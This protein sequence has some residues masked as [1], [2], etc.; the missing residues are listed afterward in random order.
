M[1]EIVKNICYFTFHMFYRVTI[2]ET[3]KKL[4]YINGIIY[5]LTILF[6]F[7]KINLISFFGLTPES[8]VE[9]FKIWQI[10]T[11]IFMHGSFIHLLFNMFMLWILGRELC[12][13]WG[14][15]FFIKYY[16]TTGI[17][18]G[19]CVVLI[20]Y[21]FNTMSYKIPTVGSSGAIFGLLLAYGLI[22]KNRI[23]YVFG[24]FP[25]KAL[26]FVIILGAI[27]TISLLSKPYSNI[28][29]LAHLGG[30]LTGYVF[31]KMKENQRK[32]S[33]KKYEHWKSKKDR[34]HVN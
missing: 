21:I 25:I 19:L 11:Y 18:A 2:P 29:H 10:F 32:Q 33:L 16:I 1:F 6:S 4:L 13:L 24:L 30:I 23:L 17:G 28:S 22:Y 15:R 9:E 12:N 27:E 5:F 7:G 3:I 26:N 31:L 20:S 14:K 8:L 34:H